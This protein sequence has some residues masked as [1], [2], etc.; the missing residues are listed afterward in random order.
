MLTCRGKILMMRWSGIEENTII[1][2][3]RALDRARTI[4]SPSSPSKY[5]H[6]RKCSASSLTLLCT[7]HPWYSSS[8][9]L[10]S[11]TASSLSVLLSTLTSVVTSFLEVKNDE[12]CC[13]R[14]S[15]FVIKANAT[16]EKQQFPSPGIGCSC[17]PHASSTLISFC[18]CSSTGLASVAACVLKKI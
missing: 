3:P 8:F 14:T 16:E 4:V 9:S 13:I 10:H 18:C 5:P 2:N 6:C 15:W 12:L 7:R 1:G 17:S 11:F